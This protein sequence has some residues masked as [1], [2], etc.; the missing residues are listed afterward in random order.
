MKYLAIAILTLSMLSCIGTPSKSKRIDINVEN[1]TG[2]DIV[3]RVKAGPI[4]KR[5]KLKK[6][7]RREF[8]ILR[9]VTKLANRV[10]VTIE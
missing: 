8:W 2:R 3:V 9:W 10:E 1:K 7:E 4:V 6:G 5:I